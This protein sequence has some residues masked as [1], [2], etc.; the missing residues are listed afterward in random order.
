LIN[1]LQWLY[2]RHGLENQR[3][4]KNLLVI[5]WKFLLCLD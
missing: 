1:G 4:C 2:N 3:V 5:K